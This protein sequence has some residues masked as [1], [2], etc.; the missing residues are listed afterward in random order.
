MEKHSTEIKKTI[1]K[2]FSELPEVVFL[3]FFF[4]S[5]INPYLTANCVF[6]KVFKP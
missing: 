5:E 3:F 1:D 6:M 4:L 2:G